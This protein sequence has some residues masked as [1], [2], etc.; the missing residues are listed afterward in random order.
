MDTLMW[1]I[2]LAIL[3]FADGNLVYFEIRRLIAFWR[4]DHLHKSTKLVDDGAGSSG[5]GILT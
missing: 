2:L 4:K 5:P 1:K 3:I